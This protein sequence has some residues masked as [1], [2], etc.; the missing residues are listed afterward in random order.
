VFVFARELTYA[1]TRVDPYDYLLW[2]VC[3]AL[4]KIADLG[5]TVAL[6]LHQPRFEI[7]SSFDDLLLLGKGA[8][9]Y[10]TALEYGRVAPMVAR[11]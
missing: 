11:F 1:C 4:R 3:G 10:D 9:V 5:I 2:Q 6:V 7:F 8:C